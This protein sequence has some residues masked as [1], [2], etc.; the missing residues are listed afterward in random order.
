MTRQGLVFMTNDDLR[1]LFRKRSPRG[2]LQSVQ[3]PNSEGR[4]RA[5]LP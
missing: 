3:V 1:E 5:Q 4:Q 2:Q